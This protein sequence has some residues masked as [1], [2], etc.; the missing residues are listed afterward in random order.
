MFSRLDYFF[1]SAPLLTSLV[2]VEIGQITWS[3]HAPITLDLSLNNA[4]SKKFYCQLNTFLL[5]RMDTKEKL[6]SSLTEFFQLNTGF[7]LDASTLWEV[8]KTYFRGQCISEG[9]R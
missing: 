2:A 6:S 7:V 9:S 8:H 3:D 1:V 4:Y 5:S